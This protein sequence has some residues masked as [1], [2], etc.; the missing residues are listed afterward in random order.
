[1]PAQHKQAYRAF[2]V[3]VRRTTYATL[4]QLANERHMPVTKYV[5]KA[6][7]AVLDAADAKSLHDRSD[8][9]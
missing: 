8:I 3:S 6:I 4:K 7:T 9:P 5:D 1:M 2:S